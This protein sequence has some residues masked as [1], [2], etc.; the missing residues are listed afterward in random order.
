MTVDSIADG[1]VIDHIPAGSG[2]RLYHLL[3]LD[4]LPAPVAL[5]VRVPSQKMGRKD[6][7]KIDGEVPLNL[8]VI[9]Y[10]DP[11]ATVNVIRGGKR[12]EKK[13]IPLPQRLTGV[14]ACKNPRCISSCEQELPQEFHLTDPEKREYRCAWC[15]AKA[16]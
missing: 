4:A 5:M 2:L 3:G 9:G 7:L 14:I 6:I 1:I 11:G 16:E 12:V 13:R 8:D 10:V 15:E